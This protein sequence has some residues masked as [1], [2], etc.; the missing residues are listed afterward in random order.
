LLANEFERRKR[1]RHPKTKNILDVVDV[2]TAED[3]YESQE[4][5][6]ED[7][8]T[9][10]EI[11]QSNLP[12]DWR[13]YCSVCG[14]CSTIAGEL[15]FVA[16]PIV[17]K[18]PTPSTTDGRRKE[19]YKQRTRRSIYISRLKLH[20]KRGVKYIHIYICNKHEM[21]SELINVNYIDKKGA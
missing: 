6:Q 10:E 18:S 8:E 3:S 1:G 4:P 16:V 13:R 7:I 20:H 9:N 2:T 14:C 17:T 15:T 5:I 21:C 11:R 12:P 19:H